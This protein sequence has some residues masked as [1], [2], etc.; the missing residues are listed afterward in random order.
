[1]TKERTPDRIKSSQCG[2]KPKLKSDITGATIPGLLPHTFLVQRCHFRLW[3]YLVTNVSMIADGYGRVRRMNR[4]LVQLD[5]HVAVVLG[6][7]GIRGWCCS[8]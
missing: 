4:L 5:Y 6:L 3:K 1:M 2:E 7:C 8:R